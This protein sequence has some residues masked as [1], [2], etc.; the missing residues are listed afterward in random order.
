MQ[1]HCDELFD[2]KLSSKFNFMTFIE[3]S[4]KCHGIHLRVCGE[5]N[6]DFFF[7]LKEMYVHIILKVVHFKR[8]VCKFNITKTLNNYIASNTF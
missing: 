5:W 7:E 2:T 3:P 1:F 8:S 4:T 6:K